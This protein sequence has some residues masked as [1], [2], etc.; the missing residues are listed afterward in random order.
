MPFWLQNLIQ[1]YN[2]DLKESLANL[3]DE[4]TELIAMSQHL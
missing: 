2:P 4:G 3:P 1:Y